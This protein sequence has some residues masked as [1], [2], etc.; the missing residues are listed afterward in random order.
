MRC[1]AILAGVIGGVVFM[2]R[3]AVAQPDKFVQTQSGKIAV[4]EVAS[5]LDHPWGMAF[6]P[7]GR[8]LVTERAGNLRIIGSDGD[9]SKPLGGTPKVYAKGSGGLLDVALDPEFS[10]NRLVYLSF[11]EPRDGGAST[12]LGRGRLQNTRI[13]GFKIIFRQ[14]P[15][16]SD[17]L[18]FGGRIVFSPQGKIFLTLG[19]R[20]QSEPVQALANDLGKVVRIN[21]DGS[22]PQDNPFVGRM[23]ARPEIW[24]YGHRNI[25]SAAINPR[26]GA[27]WIAEM[28]PRGGDELNVLEPGRDYGWP[29]VS[30]GEHYDGT[31]IP[32]PPSHPRFTDA[33]KYWT[34]AISPSGMVFYTGAVFPKWRGS[35]LIGGLSAEA[36]V[37]VKINGE[38]VTGEERIPLGA[39]IRDVAQA[40]DGSIYV[41]TDQK[42]GNVWRLTPAQ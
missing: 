40:A 30:W 7:D 19:D 14:Q 25:E 26:T 18:Q 34:P 21:R 28:G 5:G 13:E 24:T 11:A 37:R 10:S 39:R 2:S 29:V 3:P 32:N 16:V 35:I 27:L 20:H 17:S 1:I 38:N 42:D 6:L 9:L 8:L 15:K 12:A 31:A 36:I 23:D 33:I 41:L 22:I 4:Q